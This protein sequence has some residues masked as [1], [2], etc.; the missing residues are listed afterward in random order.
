MQAR[1]T[2]NADQGLEGYTAIILNCLKKLN[3]YRADPFG[4][5]K[6]RDIATRKELPKNANFD[7]SR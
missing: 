5:G 1:I 4:T 2:K 7:Q 6:T 3:S